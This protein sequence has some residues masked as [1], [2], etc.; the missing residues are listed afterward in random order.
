MRNPKERTCHLQ[1]LY[2]QVSQVR[3]K[4]LEVDTAV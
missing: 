3:D 1:T 4:H 2:A